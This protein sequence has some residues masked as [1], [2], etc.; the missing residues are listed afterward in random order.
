MLIITLGKQQSSTAI[1]Q[2][3]AVIF[4]KCLKE[5]RELN[6]DFAFLHPAENQAILANYGV[7]LIT[8]AYEE[9]Q[10]ANYIMDL[11]AKVKNGNIIDFVR[12]VSPILYSSFIA[13][14]N[15][16]FQIWKTIS[17]MLKIISMILGFL[18]K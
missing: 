16:K 7:S 1:F 4:Q 11:E 17:T 3:K 15:A 5:R 8:N 13:L 10:L 18:Q 14:P 9:E 6:V 2:R 12:S